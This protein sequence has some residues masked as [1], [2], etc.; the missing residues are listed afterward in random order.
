[1]LQY[2]EFE[3]AIKSATGDAFQRWMHLLPA[4]PM[5]QRYRYIVTIEAGFDMPTAFDYVMVSQTIPDEEYLLF[6]DDAVEKKN[7]EEGK[8]E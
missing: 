5:Q 3:K 1:M 6:L 2:K 4:I 7:K 8:A